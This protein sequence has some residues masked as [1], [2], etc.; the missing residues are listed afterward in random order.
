MNR[1]RKQVGLPERNALAN[2]RSNLSPRR[3][4]L[5]TRAVHGVAPDEEK[6]ATSAFSLPLSPMPQLPELLVCLPDARIEGPADLS[7]RAV[8]YDSREVEPGS[9]FVCIRGVAHDGHD[10][11]LFLPPSAARSPSSPNPKAPSPICP[12]I[13]PA[14]WCPI[15]AAPSR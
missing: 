15:P 4:D 9:A 6:T 11:A 2:R 3:P 12:P 13:S 5:L 10:F 8:N 7:I 14:F 1:A